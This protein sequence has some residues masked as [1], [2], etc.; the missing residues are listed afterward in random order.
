VGRD[1]RRRLI[2]TTVEQLAIG[3]ELF[4]LTTTRRDTASADLIPAGI[5][6]TDATVGTHAHNPGHPSATRCTATTT[7]EHQCGGPP[8]HNIP[9][10]RHPLSRPPPRTPRGAA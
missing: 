7:R 9:A 10:R 6:T 8:I 2:M 5:T 4:G 1:D 3:T